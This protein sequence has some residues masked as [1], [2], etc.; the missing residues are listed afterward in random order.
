M[1][2]RINTADMTDEGLVRIRLERLPADVAVGWMLQV[3]DPVEE[4]DG[5]AEVIVI[6]SDIGLAYARLRVKA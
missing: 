6:R 2:V 3:S 4:I 5:T 1:R